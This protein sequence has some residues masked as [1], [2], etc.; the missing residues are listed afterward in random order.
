MFYMARPT[1][2]SE[3]ILNRTEQYLAQSIDEYTE[4][5]KTRGEKSDSYERVLR[6]KLPTIEGLALFLGVDRSTIYE[7]ESKHKEFSYT[8]DKIRAEQQQ[9]LIDSGLSGDYNP[10][11]AKLIL[12]SNHNM[13]E[14]SDTDVTTGGNP[15]NFV[16]SDVIANK[17]GID[18]QAKGDS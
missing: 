11:I 17:N 15:V 14:K 2:Y 6:V 1:D 9:R 12:S 18:T 8:L 16:L 3:E 5:H 4:F 13:R 10:V 7:W